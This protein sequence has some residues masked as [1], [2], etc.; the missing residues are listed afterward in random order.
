MPVSALDARTHS[1]PHTSQW[2]NKL[3]RYDNHTYAHTH[4]QTH[5]HAH[6]HAC[7]DNGLLATAI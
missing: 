1:Y 2:P 6:T 4:T 5:A 3:W 7:G